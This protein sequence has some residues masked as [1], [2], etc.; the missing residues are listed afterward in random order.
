[1]GVTALT[2]TEVKENIEDLGGQIAQLFAGTMK[3]LPAR[4]DDVC[5]HALDEAF[6]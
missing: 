6:L 2:A 5:S 4:R 1:M 3:R